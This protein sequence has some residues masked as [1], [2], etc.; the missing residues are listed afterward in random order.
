M[1]SKLTILLFFFPRTTLKFLRRTML[2][3]RI[4]NQLDADKVRFIDVIIST[5]F[6]HHY[7]HHQEYSSEPTDR[8]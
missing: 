7:A 2:K 8:L 4:S 3:R 5:R 6:G 1:T